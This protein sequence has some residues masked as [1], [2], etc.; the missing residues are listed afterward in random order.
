M[1]VD[2]E[3]AFKCPES[4]RA[5]AG[6]TVPKASGSPGSAGSKETRARSRGNREAFS[7]SDFILTLNV[8]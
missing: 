4:P 6:N 5:Q 2:E 8:S 3:V 7:K 1:P